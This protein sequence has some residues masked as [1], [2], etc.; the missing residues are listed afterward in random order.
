MMGACSHLIPLPPSR[1]CPLRACPHAADVRGLC[2]LLDAGAS[3]E[4]RDPGG[5]RFG[6]CFSGPEPPVHLRDPRQQAGRA[7]ARV[8]MRGVP[9]PHPVVVAACRVLCWVFRA[10]CSSAGT[11]YGAVE[12]RFRLTRRPVVCATPRLFSIP[13]RE[14]VHLAS[15][16]CTPSCA[17]V[18]R[19]PVGL[20]C[21]SRH[22]RHSQGGGGARGNVVRRPA[23]APVHGTNA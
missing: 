20:C 22:R 15:P 13:V 17:G 23:S 4:V 16:T 10:F 8:C 14:P 5:G 21:H 11:P 1:C 6:R 7:R 2:S 3:G 19:V 9:V 12:S 18:A